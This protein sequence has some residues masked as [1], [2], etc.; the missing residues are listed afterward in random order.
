MKAFEHKKLLREEIA[1]MKKTFSDEE[2]L[3]KSAH[4]I[5]KLEE[6][7]L[8]RLSSNIACYHALRGEVQTE[9]L[10]QRWYREKQILLP[11]VEGDDLKFFLYEGEESV[12]RS[13]FGILEPRA[14]C[15]TIDEREIDLVIVP[16]VAFDRQKNRMGRGRGFY[17]RFLSNLDVPFIGIGF[18]FQIYD[19][20]PT[21]SFDKKMDMI[22][23]ESEIIL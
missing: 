21:D 15:S 13:S 18:D 11:V 9:E 1:E 22:I 8:F 6:S 14:G 12:C 19:N 2:L 20:I 5:K 17:D 23:T 7:D 16:G 4:I 10:L 3:Q